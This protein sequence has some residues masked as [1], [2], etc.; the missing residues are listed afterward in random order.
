[1]VQARASD[2]AA[3]YRDAARS[4]RPT[5]DAG[6]LVELGFTAIV[7]SFVEVGLRMSLPEA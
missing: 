6:A 5:S 7:R 4:D 2:L 3:E 1:M